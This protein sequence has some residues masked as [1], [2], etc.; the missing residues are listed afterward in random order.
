MLDPNHSIHSLIDRTVLAQH[1]DYEPAF[2]LVRL[3]LYADIA[4]FNSRLASAYVVRSTLEYRLQGLQAWLSRV[5]DKNGHQTAPY[6]IEKLAC[7]AVTSFACVGAVTIVD[8]ESLRIKGKRS[9]CSS[10]EVK[11]RNR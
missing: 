2:C 9:I 8:E 4:T 10:R 11:C 5:V 7:E 6:L 1:L 3:V